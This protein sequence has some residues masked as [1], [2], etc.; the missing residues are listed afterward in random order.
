MK[1][2]SLQERM[3]TN[4]ESIEAVKGEIK[5]LEKQLLNKKEILRHFI[6]ELKALRRQEWKKENG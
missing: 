3:K 5:E 4:H 1:D 6:N 2:L